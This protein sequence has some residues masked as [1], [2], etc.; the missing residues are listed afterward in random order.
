ME[1]MKF[2][3]KHNA[4]DVFRMELPIA[5]FIRDCAETMQKKTRAKKANVA[6]L[7]DVDIFTLKQSIWTVCYWNNI[8]Y[9]DVRDFGFA[10]SESKS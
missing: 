1:L 3:W 8:E 4:D 7:K 2:A 6:K 9:K 5:L 10:L